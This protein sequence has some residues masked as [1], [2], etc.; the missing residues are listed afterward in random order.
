MSDNFSIENLNAIAARL[1]DRASEINQITL[2]GLADDLR[3]AARIAEALSAMRSEVSEVAAKTMDS[4]TRD[5]LRDLMAR[6]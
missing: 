3:L 1:S 5:Q 4:S 2:R 6:M